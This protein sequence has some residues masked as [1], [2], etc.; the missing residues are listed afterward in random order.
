MRTLNVHPMFQSSP[1]LSPGC[2]A[3]CDAPWRS[4]CGRFQSSPKLSPGCDAVL[5]AYV[6]SH[7]FQSS[8]KL[9]PGCDAP[10]F[11][12]LSLDQR[13]N[14]HPIVSWVRPSS[15]IGVHAA[16]QFQSSPKLSPGCDAG[17]D[18]TAIDSV[19]FQSSPKLSPGCDAVHYDLCWP[20]VTV[21]I[22]TQVV[23]WVRRASVQRAASLD[24]CFNPHPIVSWVRR[25]RTRDRLR[26]RV[27]ILTQVVSW[28]RPSRQFDRFEPVVSILTQVVS[29][30]R[31]GA[32]TVLSRRAHV[33]ILTQFVSWVRRLL[34]LAGRLRR[35]NPHPICLL[36]ATCRRATARRHHARFQSSP[37]LSPGCD[38]STDASRRNCS[39]VSI[40]TQFVS[41]V[42][43]RSMP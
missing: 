37:N 13:F 30:V 4:R 16:R 1:K 2:D 41:W 14:P 10:G 39:H 12:P 35:F 3:V 28:V 34:R 24:R 33:S 18:M 29:W 19:M 36:G 11:T 7:R 9:S 27:S 42:R 5:C 22:L 43:R 6:P 8:P 23:S 17:D 38:V 21:S 20:T 32:T 31:R 26:S 25:C 40:L 15:M